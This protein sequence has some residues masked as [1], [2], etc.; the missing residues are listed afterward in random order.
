VPKIF[1]RPLELVFPRTH[2]DFARGA[3]GTGVASPMTSLI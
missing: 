2:V 1:G 3:G